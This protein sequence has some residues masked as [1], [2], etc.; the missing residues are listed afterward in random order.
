MVSV[1]F[2]LSDPYLDK[3]FATLA[4]AIIPYPA[5][6]IP[7]S[8]GS[9]WSTSYTTSGSGTVVALATSPVL[10]GPA[11]GT[12]VSGVATN[13][14]GTAAG[15][16][17]GH[18]TTNANLTGP[19]TSTGNATALAVQTGTGSTI[20]V[21]TAPTINGPILTAV[22]Q[23]LTTQTANYPIVTATDYWIICTTNAFTV[24]L[25][26]AVGISGQSFVIKNANA[27]INS[28]IMATTSAQT[29]DG[30]VPGTI[31]PLA[32]LRVVSD[33]ANWFSV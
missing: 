4:A 32:S 6:G 22:K 5:A 1:P 19:I 24:T 16:T 12:P 3:N 33:G 11:L 15:L 10:V 26:T 21:Q 29:I 2:I 30:S 14:T 27:T 7:N 31:A 8:T 28:I 23:P 9:A 25:P 20:V 18:V 17:A 13:L